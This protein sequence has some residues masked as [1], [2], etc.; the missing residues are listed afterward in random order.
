MWENRP[1]PLNDFIGRN[2]TTPR[3]DSAAPHAPQMFGVSTSGF[4]HHLKLSV[5][6]ATFHPLPTSPT[7]ALGMRGKLW[8]CPGMSANRCADT[9]THE[10][11]EWPLAI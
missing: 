1:T 6:R 2:C 7:P 5:A 3:Y 4:A 9:D 8:E 11:Y 10:N